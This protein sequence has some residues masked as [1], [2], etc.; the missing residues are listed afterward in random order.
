MMPSVLRR[1][2]R[3]AL[4]I[5][6]CVPALGVVLASRLLRRF[7]LVRFGSFMGDRIGHLAVNT[8]LY[9][10]EQDE[11]INVPQRRYVDIVF[12]RGGV[13]NH[14]LATMWKRVLNVAPSWVLSPVVE[15]NRKIPG[16]SAHQVGENTQGARDVHNLFERRPSHLRFTPPELTRG[17]EE[18][19]QMG[20][21]IGSPFVC[22]IVR[23]SEYLD[24][25]AGRDWSYHNYRDSDIRNYAMA[26]KE[27]VARGYWVIR[28]G[29]KVK[30]AFETNNPRIIDYATNGM[31]N[32]FMD[33][34]L[35]AHC[36]FC[37]ST[38]TGWGTIP[39]LFR[40]PMVY[41]NDEPIGIIPTSRSCDLFISKKC[42]NVTDGRYLTLNEVFATGVGFAR[43]TRDY[44]AR[45]V[46]PVELSP[47]EIL[48]VVVEM[49]ERLNRRWQEETHDEALQKE[50][51]RL[52]V[53]HTQ[54]QS[55]HGEILARFGAAFLRENRWWLE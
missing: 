2:R 43:S 29:A 25:V 36:T 17:Q 34:F 33:I 18:M 35:G 8:D 31:R 50:F 47:M 46:E 45:G 30:A 20:I 19:R 21:P 40:R 23:D 9:L 1:V 22:L 44:E 6:A 11:G 54:G 53:K 24:G 48:D 12:F 26:A 10:C 5:V 13:C 38:G 27:L 42:R 14:Q 52:F 51:K 3:V 4:W 39:I 15:L 55:V 37:I 49:D 7:V 32:E 16:G 28:M 41:V